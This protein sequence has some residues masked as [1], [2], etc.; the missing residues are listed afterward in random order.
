MSTSSR[1]A[2]KQKT[3]DT[4][5]QLIINPHS[6]ANPCGYLLYNNGNAAFP[7]DINRN[8]HNHNINNNSENI[9][10]NNSILVQDLNKHVPHK[11]AQEYSYE[12]Y[13]QYK[14][15]ILNDTQLWDLHMYL[16]KKNLKN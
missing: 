11:I 8:N 3:T 1:P 5:R 4:R 15:I 2:K 10:D 13:K 12:G 6:V 16:N 9:S 7:R 14:Q